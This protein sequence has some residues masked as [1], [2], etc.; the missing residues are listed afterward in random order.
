[1]GLSIKNAEVERM[2]RELAAAARRVD[3]RGAAAGAGRGGGAERAARAAEVEAKVARAW[4]SSQRTAAS[5]APHRSHRR[6]DHRL[7]RE[8]PAA[9]MVVDVGAGRDRAA[10]PGYERLR[11]AVVGADDRVGARVLPLE[12]SMVMRGPLGAGES[13]DLDGVLAAT[14]ARVLA[15]ARRMPGRRGGVPALRQGAASG[16]AELRRLHGLCGGAGGGGAAAVHRRGLR[17][18]GRG[19]PPA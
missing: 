17:A 4:R 11:G 12:T 6:R 15:F 14:G 16:G 9:L 13:G 10:E 18:D 5:A 7:R 1:M 19:G 2:V 3:D 8:R